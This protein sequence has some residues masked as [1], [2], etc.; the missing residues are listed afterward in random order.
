MIDID[1]SGS[2]RI[3]ADHILSWDADGKID[4][5]ESAKNKSIKA[6]AAAPENIQDL[7]LLFPGFV[8]CHVHFPQTNIIGGYGKD[9]LD[10]LEKNVDMSGSGVSGDVKEI[11]NTNIKDEE[12]AEEGKTQQEIYQNIINI[13]NEREK[14]KNFFF[15]DKA[16]NEIY[17]LTINEALPIYKKIGLNLQSNYP[18]IH[19]CTSPRIY[20]NPPPQ[21]SGNLISRKP[22]RPYGRFH[23]TL[24][25][26]NPR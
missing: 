24:W 20:R 17:T 22:S 14:K 5:I 19:E 9:L 21:L 15:N 12:K 16:T 26:A 4:R 1:D 8:D 18:T 11:P 10:W 6:T 2:L 25:S 13:L 7:P 3:R 23:E